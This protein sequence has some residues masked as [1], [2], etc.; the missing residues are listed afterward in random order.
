MSHKIDLLKPLPTDAC[1]LCSKAKMHTKPYQDKIELGQFLLNL[2]HIDVSGPYSPSFL[3]A[4]YYVIFLDDY[5]KT[6]EVIPLS[7]KDRVLSAFDLF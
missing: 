1:F 2:I 3:E 7:S 5:N 4:K 6:S